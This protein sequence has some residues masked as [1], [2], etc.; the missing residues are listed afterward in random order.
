MT[1]FEESAAMQMAVIKID[2]TFGNPDVRVKAT[3]CA[4]FLPA[5]ELEQFIGHCE[6]EVRIARDANAKRRESGYPF[7]AQIEAEDKRIASMA[8]CLRVL[9]DCL[10]SRQIAASNAAMLARFDASLRGAA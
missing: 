8:N 6:R 3:Q 7:A 1:S 5:D 9:N 4:A 10:I 2:W